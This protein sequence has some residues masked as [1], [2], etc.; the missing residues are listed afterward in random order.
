MKGQV[1]YANRDYLYVPVWMIQGG[2]ARM[3]KASPHI[4]TALFTVSNS[5]L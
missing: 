2:L 3:D 4:S 5:A 1:G